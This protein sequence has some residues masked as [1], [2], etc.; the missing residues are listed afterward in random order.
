MPLKNNRRAEVPPLPTPV[1][2]ALAQSPFTY[3][4]HPGLD[5]G[6]PGPKAC[7]CT[8]EMAEQVR[9]DKVGLSWRAPTR[10]LP[11]LKPLLV[12]RR[13]RVKRGMTEVGGR[14][15]LVTLLW[16]V[17]ETHHLQP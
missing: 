4:C 3:F 6:S 11:A 10:H 15:R 5:P 1:M 14:P 12:Y 17:L 8:W 9:H 16:A 2:E 13:S 7:L